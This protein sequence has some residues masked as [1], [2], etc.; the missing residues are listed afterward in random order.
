[1][2]PPSTARRRTH[3]E[4]EDDDSDSTISSD[5]TDSPKR[6]RLGSFI[7]GEPPIRMNGGN[8]N[9]AV[10]GPAAASFSPDDFAPGA[11]VRVTV[12]NFVTY[13]KAEFFPGPNLNMVIGP[14]GTG[15][16]SLVCAIC[17]GLGFHHRLLARAS[18]ARDFVK[19]NKDEAT[20]EIELRKRPKDRSNHVIRVLIPKGGDS[21]K[22]W[23]NGKETSQKNIQN[24]MR[25]L[26]IQVDNIC[27][28]L[29]QERV[30][31]FASCTPIN[32]L[33]ETLRAAAPEEMLEWQ[34]QL[35]GLHKDKKELGAGAQADADT[36]R[37]LENRQ[38]GLQADVDRIREREEIQTNIENLKGA[39]LM[40]RYQEAREKN[41]AAKQQRD[42]AKASL[43]SLEEESG[44]SLEAVYEKE[45]YAR[46]VGDMLPAKMRA[47][48]DAEKDAQ[49]LASL[50]NDAS[51]KVKECQNNIA[52][53]HKGYDAKKKELS[54]ARTKVTNLQ[55]DL[56]N[57]PAEFN[58][59]DWNQKIV[60]PA[61][62]RLESKGGANSSQ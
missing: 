41:K 51:E 1:M 10:N 44:P 17:L 2:A 22:W 4:L 40:C 39:H 47:V 19:H 28:F 27:Q 16:S 33:H 8:F 23:L 55:A 59:A 7:N 12:E 58:G 60:S 20:I 13:E 52:A 5:A 18:S 42:A 30:V 37:N 43:R 24:L 53:E 54:M 29:P 32:L 56:K 61:T 3:A 62:E 35:Q 50:A 46:R 45:K 11:I 14:N 34:S 26:K 6:P 31:E 9:G 25:Q 49:R 15:K 36:L 57:Q 21:Q 38:Q 48:K